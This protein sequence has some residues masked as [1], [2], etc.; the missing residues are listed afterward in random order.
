MKAN[1]KP[2]TNISN[3]YSGDISADQLNSTPL[4]NKNIIIITIFRPRLISADILLA[5]TMI[6]FGKLILRITSPLPTIAPTPA[7]VISEKKFH[8]TIPTN[9]PTGQWG[10]SAP[11][12]R[13]TAKTKYRMTNKNRGRKSDHT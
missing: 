8:N 5:R 9:K 6:Y 11:T 13:N 3:M 12:F 7:D 1:P 2:K 4:I 10:M